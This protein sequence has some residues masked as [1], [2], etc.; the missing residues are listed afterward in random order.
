M[1]PE[2]RAQLQAAVQAAIGKSNEKH[3]S[4]SCITQ[5]QLEKT[6]GF[7]EQHNE[8][9]KQTSV[10]RTPS[11]IE[12]HIECT[13]QQKMS[14]TYR[15]QA[16]SREAIKGDVDMVISNGD[17]KMT[18]KHTIDGKWLATDCGDVKPRDD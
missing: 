11:R 12:A 4:K 17:K 6:P 2:Q 3:V 14:G 9:C 8:S 13:G 1:T 18:S 10:T 15:F 5:K 7:T 16:V